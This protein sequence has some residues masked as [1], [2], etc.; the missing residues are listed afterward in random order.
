MEVRTKKIKGKETRERKVKEGKGKRER[1]V[2]TKER[3]GKGG[4][5]QHRDLSCE[6]INDWY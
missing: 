4:R 3:K 5:R 1:R 2:R 6:V